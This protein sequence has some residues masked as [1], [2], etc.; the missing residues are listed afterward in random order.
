M[1][2]SLYSV[3]IAWI[4]AKKKVNDG[5]GDIFLKARVLERKCNTGVS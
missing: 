5:D 4:F 3:I 2:E 1:L